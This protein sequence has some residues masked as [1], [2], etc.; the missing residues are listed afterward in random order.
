MMNSYKN[1]IVVLLV[2]SETR[3]KSLCKNYIIEFRI[4]DKNI[5]GLNIDSY[6]NILGIL[7]Y[8]SS[9]YSNFGMIYGHI[10]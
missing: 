6:D 10:L 1:N 9:K 4:V 8:W 3:V 5:Y 2:F 7:N